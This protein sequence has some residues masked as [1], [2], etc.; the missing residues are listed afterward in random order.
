MSRLLFAA[1]ALVLGVPAFAQDYG[2]LT[3][4][5]GGPGPAS[6]LNYLPPQGGFYATIVLPPAGSQ[7]IT[8][9]N[10][11]FL[12]GNRHIVVDEAGGYYN[13]PIIGHAFH[14][15]ERDT[16]T[17]LPLVTV[18]TMPPS[19]RFAIANLVDLR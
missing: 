6:G 7:P 19:G 12:P 9:R 5:S 2:Y 17:Y 16:G 13:P 10:L 18:P 14:L 3:W 8:T 1:A 15:I 4:F 11:A